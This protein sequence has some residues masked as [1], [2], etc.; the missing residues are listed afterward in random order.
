MK[1]RIY[2]L[3]GAASL[4][5]YATFVALADER[6]LQPRPMEE[7]HGDCSNFHWDM[8]QEFEVWKEKA[9]EITAGKSAEEPPA[10]AL[11]TRY[12]V[13]LAPHEDVAFVVAPEKDRGGSDKFSGLLRVEIPEDGLYRI[14]AS[15][16]LWID[17]LV[18]GKTVKSNSFEMQTGCDTIFKSVAY[19]FTG[20]EIVTFQLNGS[21][22]P[23]VDIAVT[24]SPDQ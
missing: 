2:G 23:Q 16:G 12:T 10:L 7:M 13:T 11:S 17:A 8:S 6:E 9:A 22:S 19:S 18:D 1:Y 20:G 21:R 4:T 15:N 24:A 5:L 3:V 14:S